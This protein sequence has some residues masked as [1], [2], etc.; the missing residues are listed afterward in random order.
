MA[1]MALSTLCG[2]TACDM[3]AARKAGRAPALYGA[4]V[5]VGGCGG[6][7]CVLG[8]A[9]SA[10]QAAVDDC[11]VSQYQQETGYAPF[12]FAGS[13]LGSRKF[14][15]LRLRRCREAGGVQ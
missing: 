1:P 8:L 13:S 3:L 9:G 6:T 11:L 15:H 10:G 2:S 5:T 14:G 12:V 4:K 7:V